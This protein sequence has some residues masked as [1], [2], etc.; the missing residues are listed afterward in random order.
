MDDAE[1]RQRNRASLDQAFEA[2]GRGDADAMLAHYTDDTIMELPFADPPLRIDGKPAILDYLR[3]AFTV[4]QIELG[5]TDVHECR[6]PDRLVIEFTSTGRITS[7]GRSYANRIIAVY[8][9]RDGR[10]AHWREFV[11]PVIVAEA[12]AP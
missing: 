3:Q 8:W 5:V 2:I 9:F 11:N 7:T 10:V 4:F 1:I 6:D 12:M